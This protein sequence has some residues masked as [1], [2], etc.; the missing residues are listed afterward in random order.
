MAEERQRITSGGDKTDILRLN[1][2]TKVKER[3]RHVAWEVLLI[4]PSDG[5]MLSCSFS[6]A[7]D[8]LL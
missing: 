5:T 1:E 7:S 2:L 4:G 3:H 6:R 8:L